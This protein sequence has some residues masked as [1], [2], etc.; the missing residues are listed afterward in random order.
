MRA[1]PGLGISVP[2]AW[3]EL[4]SVTGGAHWHI[5]NVHDRIEERVDPWA[6]YAGTKQT[7]AKAAKALGVGR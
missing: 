1:R 5:R 7:L 6:A 3:D 2:C 4:K